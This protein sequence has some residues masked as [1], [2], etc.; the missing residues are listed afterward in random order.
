M[1]ASAPGFSSSRRSPAWTRLRRWSPRS[2][3]ARRPLLAA[4]RGPLEAQLGRR[5]PPG[6][7]SGDTQV[8]AAAW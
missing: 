6:P 3:T 1:G 2:T 5:L 7:A 4:S 8:A